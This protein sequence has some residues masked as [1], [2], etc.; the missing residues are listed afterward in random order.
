MENRE[1]GVKPVSESTTESKRHTP[2]NKRNPR[3]TLD[4]VKSLIAKVP[5]D[6]QGAMVCSIVGH[7]RI[8]SSCFGYIT[9]ERCHVQIADKLVGS[10]AQAEACVQVGHNCE[11]CRLNYQKMNW[12]DKFMVADPLTKVI[13]KAVK[14]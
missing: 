3:I 8:V 11:I 9:C 6:R 7:S 12:R 14:S 5:K 13:Q 2:P 10:Y 1:S 4:L